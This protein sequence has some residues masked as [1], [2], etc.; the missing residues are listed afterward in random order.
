[1]PETTTRNYQ[2][3]ATRGFLAALTKLTPA[4]QARTAR[5]MRETTCF[6]SQPGNPDWVIGDPDIGKPT[7]EDEG[8]T[9]RVPAPLKFYAI[10]DDHGDGK[11]VITFMLPEDY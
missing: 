8:R 1:M 7:T 5:I 11:Y 10:A 6:L 3:V 4:E 9:A 2:T